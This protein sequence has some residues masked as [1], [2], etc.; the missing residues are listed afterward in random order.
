MILELLEMP[1][2]PDRPNARVNLQ[3][4]K[5]MTTKYF[6][7][8][9][10]IWFCAVIPLVFAE[11]FQNRPTLSGLNETVNQATVCGNAVIER[12]VVVNRNQNFFPYCGH[13]QSY[14]ASL[15]QEF[16]TLAPIYID[17]ENGPLTDEGDEFL[18]F[19]LDNWRAAAGLNASG[20][21]RST[22]GTTFYYGQMQVGDTI[23]I[24]IFEDLQK[25]FGALKQVPFSEI[26]HQL[27]RCFRRLRV[28][29]IILVAEVELDLVYGIHFLELS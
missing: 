1:A 3:R 4:E 20:F 25:G 14:F 28:K 12:D 13:G 9:L 27:E 8:V 19:D 10:A 2:S 29:W 22:D 21:R 18:Y 6:H 17:H 15:Q 24:W 26:L 11:D 7:I 16:E 5:T 23:G